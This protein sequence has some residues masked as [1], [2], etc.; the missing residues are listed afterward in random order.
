MNG[1]LVGGFVELSFSTNP[2]L[3]NDELVGGFAEKK[4]W[5]GT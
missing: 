5:D 2:F 1:D 4:G 3:R